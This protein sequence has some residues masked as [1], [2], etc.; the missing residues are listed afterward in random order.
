M[1]KRQIVFDDCYMC[2]WITRGPGEK[3]CGAGRPEF[4]DDY[5]TE[6]C[7]TRSPKAELWL[8]QRHNPNLVLVG[9]HYPWARDRED[10]EWFS[11]LARAWIMEVM[12]DT[13]ISDIDDPDD[14]ELCVHL[15]FSS[16]ENAALF[17]LWW[18]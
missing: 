6:P 16:P 12:P 14:L 4:Y 11:P 3:W 9:R 7:P 15:V 18:S 5:A 10:Y 13:V 1:S 2:N 8:S 17:K